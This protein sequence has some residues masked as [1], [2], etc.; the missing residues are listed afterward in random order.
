M[1]T[2][3]CSVS[4]QVVDSHVYL[5]VQWRKGSEALL[6]ANIALGICHHVS[7]YTADKRQNYGY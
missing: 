6:L 4:E 5:T 1:P 7:T 2:V 3:N